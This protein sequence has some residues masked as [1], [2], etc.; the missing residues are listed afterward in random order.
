MALCNNCVLVVDFGYL[1]A[2]LKTQM[3]RAYV[4]V[5][6][7]LVKHHTQ[8]L[9]RQRSDIQKEYK[10]FELIVLLESQKVIE[11]AHVRTSFAV[12]F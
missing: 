6:R 10:F 1:L 5:A 8:E 12:L 4:L 2:L 9:L 11:K 7:Q 3:N